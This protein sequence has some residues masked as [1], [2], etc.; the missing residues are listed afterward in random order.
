MK[1]CTKCGADKSADS[2]YRGYGRCKAC[3][4]AMASAWNRANKEKVNANNRAARTRDPRRASAN[5]SRRYQKHRAK[6]DELVL[7][8]RKEHPDFER[9]RSKASNFARRARIKGA[10]GTHTGTEI[11]SLVASYLG[12]CAYCFDAKAEHID[13]VVPVAKGGTN[14]IGNLVPACARCNLSKGSRSLLA[15]MVRKAG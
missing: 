4:V 12:R 3:S 13:H 15:F 11:R 7:A 6:R 9:A 1:T 10:S 14:D 2:F 5:E 8:Y